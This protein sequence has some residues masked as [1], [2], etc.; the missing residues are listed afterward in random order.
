[1][2]KNFWF[3]K[4]VTSLHLFQDDPPVLLLLRELASG[5][6]DHDCERIADGMMFQGDF[7]CSFMWSVDCERI[8]T[9]LSLR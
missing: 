9:I 1:M 4:K 2:L 7:F 3:S 8:V 6:D 5:N